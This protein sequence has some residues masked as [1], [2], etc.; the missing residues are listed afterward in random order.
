MFFLA[1]IIGA[2]A[3]QQRLDGRRF[4][5]HV[6]ILTKCVTERIVVTM[7]PFG[8]ACLGLCTL[9]A[10]CALAPAAHA[11]DIYPNRFVK[12]IVPYSAG[13]GTDVVAR[14]IGDKLA[15]RLGQPVVIENKPG[16]GARLGTE[17]VAT[18]PADG[19]TMLI[20]GG[21]EM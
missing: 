9:A 21:S 5:K 14:V 8:V 17:F 2:G 12:I 7:H 15:E 13:G 3:G 6:P 10:A 4:A 16:A 11:Q 1:W 20:A 18:Q 19:Y